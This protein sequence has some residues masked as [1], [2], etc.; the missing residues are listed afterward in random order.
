MEMTQS[1]WL[2]YLDR[3]LPASA[4]IGGRLFVGCSGGP[5]SMVLL[6][7]LRQGAQ[8]GYWPY[9]ILLHVNYGL[10]GG[11]SEADQQLVEDYA[12]H[13]Q[14]ECRLHQV[15][16]GSQRAAGQAGI[17]EWARNIR[18]SWFQDQLRPSDWLAL[19]HHKDDLAENILLRLIRGS[20]LNIAGMSMYDRPYW[21]PL[22]DFRKAVL[23][24]L[25]SR[26]KV[27]Y[28]LD[29]SNAKL[30]YS[31]N[32]I[33]LSVIPELETLNTQAVSKITEFGQDLADCEA[34]FAEIFAEPLRQDHLAG[35]FLRS[36]QRGV[37]FYVVAAFLKNRVGPIQLSRALLQRIWHH[38]QKSAAANPV[39]WSEQLTS[40]VRVQLV[41]DR[42]EVATQRSSSGLRAAQHRA[43]I[44]RHPVA[45]KLEPGAELTLGL[46]R[47]R[48]K[49]GRD[50][51]TEK[52]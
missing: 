20:G 50:D 51:P 43:N 30:V 33:R 21:R 25:A 2:E 47:L 36:L 44:L 27:P 32:R 26:Q 40:Q 5:D 41:H 11:Q 16:D 45:A 8:A 28:R 35:D 14:L 42:L 39:S 10:R 34:Y 6:D 22:L 15:P 13:W 52:T 1:D 3:K 7:L 9:P 12:R 29:E 37:V 18:R 49:V 48:E 4:R 17:Q 38:V 46:A 23:E 24:D 31:R 19:A